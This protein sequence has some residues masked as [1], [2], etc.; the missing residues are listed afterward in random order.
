MR[1]ARISTFVIAW[2]AT[3]TVACWA[4][5]VTLKESGTTY[6]RAQVSAWITPQEFAVA[7]WDGTLTIF[8]PPKA[9]EFGPVLLEDS[10][11]P[12]LQPVQMITSI[13]SSMFVTSNDSRSLALWTAQGQLFAPKATLAFDPQYGTADS[14]AIVNSHGDTWLVTGHEQGEVLIWKI[15]NGTV[16]YVKAI[17][18]RSSNP[19]PSPYQLWNVRG[20]VPWQDHFVLTGS[21]DG[22]IV[23]VSVPDGSIKQRIRYNPSAQRGINALAISGDLLLLANCSVGSADKN[24]WLYRVSNNSINLLDSTNLDKAPGLPQVFDFS[25]S[26]ARKDKADYFL[27]STEEGLLWLGKIS[28]DKLQ[29]LT[30]TTV[31]PNGGAALSVDTSTL[32]IVAA[33]FDVRL[34]TLVDGPSG[35]GTPAAPTNQPNH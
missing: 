16:S 28:G 34:F 31:A 5:D 1:F 9:G 33:A 3:L 11:V 18:I 8:R 14:G 26:F 20:I 22:D 7:R 2:A 24:L 17:S 29:T 10:S 6:G 23:L 35:K 19:I 15:D 32:S 4:Q 21:E 25:V 30:N 12:S 27:A 13:S